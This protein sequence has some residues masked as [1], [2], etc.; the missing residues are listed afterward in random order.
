ME[1]AFE[2]S[3]RQTILVVDDEESLREFLRLLLKRCGYEVFT[4]GDGVAALELAQEMPHLD[5]LVSDIEMP[6]MRGNEL[7]N[8]L[9]TVHP[10]AAIV[11]VSSSDP[12]LDVRTP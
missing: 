7:A 11:F 1:A 6:R 2:F 4:A 5:A 12:P 8:Q 9:A 3:D 10:E